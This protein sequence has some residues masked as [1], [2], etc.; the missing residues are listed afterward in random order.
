MKWILPLIILFSC[1]TEK[2]TYK[3]L[4][5]W[6]GECRTGKIQS[7]ISL[8]NTKKVKLQ[9]F[10]FFYK[11]MTFKRKWIHK[12]LHGIPDD[13]KKSY[14]TYKGKKFF[15]HD[16][17]FHVPSSHAIDDR[18]YA[19]ETHLVHYSEKGERLVLGSF[20]KFGK[21]NAEL[22]RRA[23]KVGIKP[24][25]LL[26]KD[27]SSYRYTGSLTTPPCTEDVNWVIM[28]TPLTLGREQIERFMNP[29]GGFNNRPT[30]PK[31]NRT[32]YDPN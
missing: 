24:R 29:G 8:D 32:I 26:P 30:Q 12:T 5:N 13:T 20:Y 1:S 14:V 2:W 28:K 31:N 6:E 3:D 27:Q 11:S 15:F 19:A 21:H 7:P 17:H 25:D 22:E 10:K 23:K 18:F 4:E 16:I 9:N